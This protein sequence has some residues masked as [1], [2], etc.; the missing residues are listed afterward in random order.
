MNN[1]KVVFITQAALIA[2]LYVTL[3]FVFAAISFGE[4]QL[5]I[6][7]ALTILPMFT[8]AAI[9]G[10]FVGCIIGNAMGGAVLPDII[11]GSLATLIGAYVTWLLRNRSPFIGCLPPI[12]ANM[13]VVPFVLRYAY[14]VTLPLW[15]MALT[16]GLGEVLGCGLLG[17]ILYFALNKHGEVIFKAD[18]FERI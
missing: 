2:A 15:F 16:V 9:P 10:L 5:R 8:P 12:I 18:M 3:T 7:E 13:I 17:C 6:A 14:A 4:V 11:C 1:K